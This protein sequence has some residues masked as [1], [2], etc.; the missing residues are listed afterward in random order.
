MARCLLLEDEHWHVSV[1]VATLTLPTI[2]LCA[3]RESRSGQKSEFHFCIQ[4]SY[5]LHDG[6]DNGNRAQMR[7]DGIDEEACV[8]VLETPR[9]KYP[10]LRAGRVSQRRPTVFHH[11]HSRFN[12]SFSTTSPKLYLSQPEDERY[13]ILANSVFHRHTFN[14]RHQHQDQ[15]IY[16]SAAVTIL[17]GLVLRSLRCK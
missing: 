15:I 3:R 1:H 13:S 10:F 9:E 17:A 5:E 2:H 16:R 8:G 14:R 11:Q 6:P 7:R 4:A 12:P